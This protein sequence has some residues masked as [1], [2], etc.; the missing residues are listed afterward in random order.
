MANFPDPPELIEPPESNAIIIQREADEWRGQIMDNGLG[1]LI[2]LLGWT[3][4]YKED[5]YWVFY[6]IHEQ[7]IEFL[8]CVG[9]PKPLDVD[10]KI[11]KLLKDIK[12][13]IK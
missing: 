3:D 7:K 13:V 4:S 11:K 12:Y 10:K 1:D 2:K 5:Y 9:S 6:N 8:S